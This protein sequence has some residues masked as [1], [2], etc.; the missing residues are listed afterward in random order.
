MTATIK[1]SATGTLSNTATASATDASTVTA[2]D[3]DTLTAQGHPDH[4]QDRRG[5]LRS[6]A[7][8]TDTYTIVVS[9]TGPE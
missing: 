1:S 5:H 3:T 4:H 2:T 9:N 7:G 8:T 6:T